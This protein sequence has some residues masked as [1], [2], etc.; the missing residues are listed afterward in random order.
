[1]KTKLEETYQISTIIPE[2]EKKI[3]KV[4]N[5]QRQG[6]ANQNYI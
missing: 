1:M 5:K 3:F 2:S 4:R 6:N